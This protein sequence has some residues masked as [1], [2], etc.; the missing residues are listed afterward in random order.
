MKRADNI[1]GSPQNKNQETQTSGTVTNSSKTVKGRRQKPKRPTR[2]VQFAQPLAEQRVFDKTQSPNAE[3][4][5]QDGVRKSKST[6]NDLEPPL[7]L[8]A[9]LD[10]AAKKLNA[11]QSKSVVEERETS[12]K[13]VKSAKSSLGGYRESPRSPSGAPKQVKKS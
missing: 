13:T 3:A 4:N 10:L 5:N 12:S 8:V 1:Q 9:R 7:S 11:R 2:K 6:L